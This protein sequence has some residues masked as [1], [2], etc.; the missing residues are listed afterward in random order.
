MSRGRRGVGEVE[1]EE[2]REKKKQADGSRR[3]KGCAARLFL[4]LACFLLALSEAV[5]SPEGSG[6][7]EG[8]R[9]EKDKRE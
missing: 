4:L 5:R 1:V 8:R 2:T 6:L 9:E 3:K 7:R